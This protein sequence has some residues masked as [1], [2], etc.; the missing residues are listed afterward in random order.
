MEEQR[1]EALEREIA[2]EKA[3][4]LGRGGRKLRIAL[5]NLRRFDEGAGGNRRNARGARAELIEIA[6]DAL[7]AYVVQ[8]EAMG[9]TD[10]EY[11]A[12]EYAVPQE[13]WRRMRPG[14]GSPS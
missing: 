9:L 3:A 7:Y 2:G 12:R 11:V 4:A 10:A 13:V 1:H 8:R 6:G 14:S 5:D